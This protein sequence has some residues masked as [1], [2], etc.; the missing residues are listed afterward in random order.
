LCPSPSSC[1]SSQVVVTTRF[2]PNRSHE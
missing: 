2:H 1:T